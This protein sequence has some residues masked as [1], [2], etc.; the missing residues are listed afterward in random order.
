MSPRDTDS[1]YSLLLFNSGIPQ[2]HRLFSLSV[3]T[4]FFPLLVVVTQI[5]ECFDLGIACR[6]F[7]G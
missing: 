7:K 1:I 6:S 5:M 3:F 2:P 4:F